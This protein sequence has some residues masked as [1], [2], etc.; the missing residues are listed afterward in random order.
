[1][2]DR[3]SNISYYCRRRRDGGSLVQTGGLTRTQ[4]LAIRTSLISSNPPGAN[5]LM[6]IQH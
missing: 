5:R 4:H 2:T 1:V 3:E 6:T